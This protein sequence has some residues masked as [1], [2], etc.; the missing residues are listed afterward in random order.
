MRARNI[1]TKIIKLILGDIQVA[2]P[3]V[4]MTKNML[5]EEGAMG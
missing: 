2:G 1:K 5:E 3:H 4:K